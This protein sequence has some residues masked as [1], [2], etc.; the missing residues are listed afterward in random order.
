MSNA[1]GMELKRRI[2]SPSTEGQIWVINSRLA[3][4]CS[5]LGKEMMQSIIYSP[6]E[7]ICKCSPSP[8]LYLLLVLLERRDGWLP[9]SGLSVVL[10]IT[11]CWLLRG[12]YGVTLTLG[13]TFC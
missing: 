1:I 3:N 11:P 2:V 8:N 9:N 12:M 5:L 10:L 4:S 13:S 7:S 6:Y